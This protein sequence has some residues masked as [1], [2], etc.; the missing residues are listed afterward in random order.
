[1]TEWSRPS[2]PFKAGR[3]KATM[4]F[5]NA[6]QAYHNTHRAVGGA[7]PCPYEQEPTQVDFPAI[8]GLVPR[9]HNVSR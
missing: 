9:N 2:Q 4:H 3:R 5:C 1:M 6:C 7:Q 8:V